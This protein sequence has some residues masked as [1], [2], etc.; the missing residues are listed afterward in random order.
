M[1]KDLHH[2]ATD[3]T[4]ETLTYDLQKVLLLPKISTNVIY[5]KR[6]L[7]LYNLGVHSGKDQ[8]GYFYVWMENEGGRGAQDVGSAVKNTSKPDFLQLLSI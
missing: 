2:A 7:N 5:Y 4:V 8:K 6:Q 1:N 3:P